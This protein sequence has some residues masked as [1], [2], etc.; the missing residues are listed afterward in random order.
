MIDESISYCPECYELLK[1]KKRKKR[2]KFK[3]KKKDEKDW[4]SNDVCKKVE[5]VSNRFTNRYNS[6]EESTLFYTHFKGRNEKILNIV[7]E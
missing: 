2:F 4:S 3:K 7:V 5:S 6:T 1:Q